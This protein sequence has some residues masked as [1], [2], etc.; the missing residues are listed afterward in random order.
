LKN[1]REIVKTEKLSMEDRESTISMFDAKRLLPL[2]EFD[3]LENIRRT[4]NQGH[5][6]APW[7]ESRYDQLLEKVRKMMIKEH[8]EMLA[9]EYK[10]KLKEDDFSLKELSDGWALSSRQEAIKFINK[11]FPDFEKII[12]ESDPANWLPGYIPKIKDA[13]KTC[14]EN[15]FIGLMSNIGHPEAFGYDVE[16]WPFAVPY[17]NYNKIGIDSLEFCLRPY[18]VC[19]VKIHR[20]EHVKKFPGWVYTFP[21]EEDP[22]CMFTDLLDP[23]TLD[24]PLPKITVP[25]KLI[26]GLDSENLQPD[27]CEVIR[28]EGGI[29]TYMVKGFGNEVTLSHSFMKFLM[30]LGED[31][32]KRLQELGLLSEITFK[33]LTSKKEEEPLE[34]PVIREKDRK[35]LGAIHET[36]G[37]LTY[38]GWGEALELT[39]DGAYRTLTRLEEDGLVNTEKH[40]SG[41]GT[42]ASLTA[43][44][45]AAIR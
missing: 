40:E 21:S 43:L 5:K 15:V 28:Q 34:L 42:R 26:L 31:P 12:E 29:L 30:A 25:L 27:G 6:L 18:A 16:I 44:G 13:T 9:E 32:L 22:L 35:Y 2:W 33:I 38:G 20:A 3:E 4:M 45:L 17:V 24:M 36:E 19:S 37:F 23:A 7:A 11:T 10:E 41:E 14:V 8:A 1:I 39:R